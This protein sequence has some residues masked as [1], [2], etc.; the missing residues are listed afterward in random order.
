MPSRIAV[1]AGWALLSV[2]CRGRQAVPL[3]PGDRV[4][5]ADAGAAGSGRGD[6]VAGSGDVSTT[7][8]RDGVDAG[9]SNAWDSGAQDGSAIACPRVNFLIAPPAC[10]TSP[11]APSEWLS[12]LTMDELNNTVQDLLVVPAAIAQPNDPSAEWLVTRAQAIAQSVSARGWGPLLGCP[13]TTGD[14]ACGEAFI[15]SFGRLA[16]RRPLTTAER[17][18]HRAVF[19]EALSSSGTFP[20]AIDLLLR[21]MLVAPQFLYRLELSQGTRLYDHGWLARLDAWEVAT[22][23]SLFL[24][25][26]G[27]D[28]ALLDKAARGALATS[29]AVEAEARQMLADPRATRGT[30]RIFERWLRLDRIEGTRK[31]STRFPDFTAAIA[32]AMR[33][34]TLAFT[35]VVMS[36]DARLATLLTGPFTVL[37]DE[38]ATF[39]RLP[40]PGSP[41]P[42][43]VPL[44][45]TRHAGILTQGSFLAVNASATESAPSA[46]GFD[47]LDKLFCER[48]PSPDL[49]HPGAAAGGPSSRRADFERM[50]AEPRCA[51]CHRIAD[52][53]G[54]AFE[55]YDAVGRWRDTD[56]VAPIDSSGRICDGRHDLGSFDG[57]PALGAAL[58]TNPEVHRCVVRTW[59][60]FGRGVPLHDDEH[61]YLR[62]IL[63]RFT[64]TRENLRELQLA[65]ASS[66]LF[67]TRRTSR[68]SVPPPVFGPVPA[69]ELAG[70]SDPERRDRE[71]RW[72]AMLAE[73]A[74]KAVAAQLSDSGKQHLVAFASRFAEAAQTG[75]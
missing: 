72:I 1:L 33:D 5:P 63:S 69:L 40:A 15:E 41:T 62:E 49:T 24:W 30:R 8:R 9:G 71:W 47:L 16:F 39:Y 66:T 56:N 38:L 51:S 14:Q 44:N 64:G 61:C 52:P 23:L 54:F 46:R 7:V 13:V 43:V 60:T 65:I 42:T 37:G 75:P 59:L 22:R 48:Y 21:S 11:S 58:A 73:L 34:E 28:A 20:K 74:F 67:L 36:G 19:A 27:P 50:N 68:D 2:G 70:L 4:S 32:R 18:H 55:G 31:D 6:A 29:T 10:V 35:D 26:S 17:E 3:H 53:I 57:A 45:P 12:A 25:A